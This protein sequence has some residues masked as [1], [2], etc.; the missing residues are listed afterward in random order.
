MPVDHLATQSKADIQ[1]KVRHR[2]GDITQG[3]GRGLPHTRNKR[4]LMV[5]A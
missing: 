2:K 1:P 4:D 3:T 5:I